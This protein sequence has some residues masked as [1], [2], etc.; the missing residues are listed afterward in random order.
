VDVVRIAFR[1]LAY[2]AL[3]FF[4]GYASDAASD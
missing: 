3:M 1:L 4:G 2:F